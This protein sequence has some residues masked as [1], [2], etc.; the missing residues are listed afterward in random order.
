MD[1]ALAGHN[2]LICSLEMPE[3]TMMDRLLAYVAGIHG[4]AITDPLRYS[5]E[6]LRADRPTMAFLN[7]IKSAAQKINASPLA[8]E[9]LIG[10]NVYQIAARIRRAHRKQ[11]VVVAVVDFVQRIRPVPDMRRES[12]EQQ[13]AHASNHLCDL[14]KELGFCL[15]LPSQ[16]NKEG[17]AKHA[18]AI[19]EDAD[20]HLQIVQDRSG[21]S[22]TYAHQ[23]IA[24]VKDRHAGHDGTLL[25]IVL[26]GPMLRFIPKNKPMF[27]IWATTG[28]LTSVAASRL[29]FQ[30]ARFLL[31]KGVHLTATRSE[32]YYSIAT[33]AGM[34]PWA[35]QEIFGMQPISQSMICKVSKAEDTVPGNRRCL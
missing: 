5:K 6:I 1:A 12:R 15:L 22:P 11:P 27:G 32:V 31:M 28:L 30:V 14:S 25:Q 33:V 3:Q 29:K 16:L 2:T 24:V 4:D 26:D 10:A 13:L 21:P 18:E 17:A 8:I 23:G 7:S 35:P 20:L 19:N 34:K 9:D